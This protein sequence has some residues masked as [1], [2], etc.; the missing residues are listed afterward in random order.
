MN[1]LLARV[2]RATR[3]L[4][5]YLRRAFSRRAFHPPAV[6]ALSLETTSV[7]NS[8]C[9]F[10]ANRV[11]TRAR[12]PLP[13]PLFTAAVDQYAAMGGR[14]IDFNTI[15]GD[16][17]LD[18]HLLERARYV[19]RFPQFTS[20]GFITTLQ[21]LHRFDL[22][23]FLDAGFTWL[24]VSTTLTGPD[25]YRAF[26]GVAMYKTMLDNLLR[27][28][29][30]VQERRQL[31]VY[32]DVKPTPEPVEAILNHPDFCKVRALVGDQLDACVRQR[33]FYVAD[34]GGAVVP[35]PPLKLRPLYPRHFLPCRLLYK[36][37]AVF[38]NGRVGACACRDY[39]ADG[40]LIL[41]HIERHTLAELW[42]GEHLARIR[43]D[44]RHRNKIP[45]ICRTCR[46]YMY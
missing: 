10:C 19:R 44:W 37:L 13:L 23:E 46:H 21:W 24:A 29:A 36:G 7:C 40:D 11:M 27:L 17:L 38:S 33:S 18:P 16:P 32:V 28:L 3:M 12:Q 4:R 31:S 43:H 22:E 6:P 41:G 15:I 42:H 30:A 2:G 1:P 45:A 8:R 14:A 9:G 34:W 39:N 35:P 25:T 5:S 26:F 20:N